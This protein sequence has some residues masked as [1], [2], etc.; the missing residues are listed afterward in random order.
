MQVRHEDLNKLLELQK[1]DVEALQSKKKLEEL[2]QRR[3]I[4]ELRKK[5][6]VVQEKIDQVAQLKKDKELSISR[7]V[8]EDERLALKQ[9]EVQKAIDEAKG[10]YRNLEARTKELDGHTRRRGVL[11]EQLEQADAELAKI[12]AAEKQVCQALDALNAQEEAA[13]RS[14]QE[15][16]GVLQRS[17]AQLQARAA[18]LEEELPQEL[19]ARYRK[20]AKR[21]G[22]VAVGVLG[23]GK[24][25]VCRTPID[26]ARMSAIRAQAPLGECPHCKRLLIVS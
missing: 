20:V 22:G 6:A 13:V 16:G 21:C 2:P 8:A 26:D 15:E 14:F 7:I 9:K 11:E 18:S 24:C 4:L 25:G 12:T 1:V 5:K 23:D 3:L 17:V 19:L 10:D